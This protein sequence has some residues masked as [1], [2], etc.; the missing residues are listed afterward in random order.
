M[1]IGTLLQS[2]VA[3]TR[4]GLVRIR[5]GTLTWIET[6]TEE[7]FAYLMLL[8][9]FALMG[10]MAVWPL[11]ETFR[12][13]LHADALTGASYVGE[14]VGLENYV[15]LLTGERDARLVRPFLSFERPFQ[16]AIPVTLVFTV[17]VVLVETLLGFAMAL[18]L[19]KEFEGRRWV[20]VAV[21]V[22]WTVPIVIQGLIFFLMFSPGVGFATPVLNDLGIVSETPLANSADALLLVM[23][24]D[25][26]KQTPFM[27]LLILAGLQSIDR[28]LYRVAR[29]SGA[30]MWQRFR[31]ITFPLVL[32][33]LFVAMLF[34][35][36]GAT[37][38]FGPIV[39]ISNCSTVPSLTCVVV[40]SFSSRSYGS[41]SA[42]AFILAVMVGLF[43]LIYLV[44]FR[45]LS[46][47]GR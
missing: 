41:S 12:L 46:F 17:G 44:Q 45:K 26:W 27:A 10:A 7:Q 13:S 34:R 9:V 36:I 39:V 19:D 20:R 38:I 43:L 32:P 8:P 16:S 18:L 1:A 40:S 22:P 6:L 47:G 2:T 37:K 5:S 21:I 31:T 11:A 33:T 3:D 25:V 35:T 29:V 28:S 14:F 30:S 4:R 15:E 42:L 24:S 23:L